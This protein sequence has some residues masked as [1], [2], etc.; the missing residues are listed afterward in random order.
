MQRW[1]HLTWKWTVGVIAA[2]LL[3]FAILVGLFRLLAPLAPGYREQVQAGASQAL[4]RPVN[5]AAVGAQWGLYGPEATLEKV[6]I[7]S[8]DGQRV[9]ISANEIR[10]GYTLGAMLHGRFSRPNRII[11]IQPKLDLD[12]DANGT[13]S[14]HGL[15]SSSAPTNWRQEGGEIFA[16]SADVLVRGGEIT[17]IDKRSS[18]SPLVFS[19]IRLNVENTAD[20]HKVS[21]RL[22]LPVV[23]GRSLSFAGDIQGRA[24][25]PESWQWQAD[26]QGSALNV[27][28]WLSY[29]PIFNKRFSSGQLDL[30]AD[31]SGLGASINRLMAEVH[32]QQ[33]TSTDNHTSQQGFNLLSGTVNWSRSAS[34]WVLTG[35]NMQVQR[36]RESWP[37]SNF[38]LRY[39]HGADESVTW[40]G[41]TSFLRLQDVVTLASW[42]PADIYSGSR[43]MLRLAPSGDIRDIKFQA[44]W[45]GKSIDTWALT[46]SFN[47]L[48]LRADGKIPGFS[49]LSG[50]LRANQDTGDLRFT[51]EHA[52][53]NFPRLFRGPLT[54]TTMSAQVRFLHDAQGWHIFTDDFSAANPDLQVQAKGAFLLPADGSSPLIDLQ[55]SAQNVNVKS[56]STYLPVGI[57]PNKVVNWLDNSIVS[58]QIPSGSLILRGRLQDFP[59]DN[60]QGLFDIRFHLVNGVLDYAA[61]WPRAQDLDADVEF[62]NQGMSVAVQHGTYLGD[63]ISGATANFADLRQGILVIKGTA[64][65][66]AAAALNFLR[67]E[68]LRQYFGH[69]LDSLIAKGR[70][71]VSLHLVLPVEQMDSYT[72]DSVAHLQ[73]V[74]V[75]VVNRPKLQ[76]SRL[77]GDVKITRDGVSSDQLKGTLLGEPLTISL[78]PDTRQDMTL[79]EVE[80]GGNSASLAGV[81]PEPFQKVMSGNTAWQLSGRITSNTGTS[82]KSLSLTLT[83]DLSGLG[84]ELPAPLGKT[85]EAAIPLIASMSYSSDQGML[86]Q[87]RYGD[88]MNGLSLFKDKNGSWRFD[89]GELVFGKGQSSLPSTSG[90]MVTGSLPEFSLGAWQSYAAQSGSPAGQSLPAWL[91]GVDLKVNHFTGYGQAIDN[92]HVLLTR[93]SSIWDITLTSDAVAGKI[94]LPY[95]VDNVHPITADMQRVTWKYKPAKPENNPT[96]STLKPGDVP[97]L[98]IAVKQLR[99]NDL[100][101]ENVKAE[102]ERQ[103]DGINLKSFAITN[104]AFSLT[105]SG[106]WTMQADGKQQSMLK[107]QMKSS[108][109]EKTLQAFGY[110]P[111]ID[112]KQGEM[113]TSLSWPGGPFDNIPPILKG[114]LHMQLKNGRLLEVR[115]G[116]GRLFGL[117]SINALPRRLLLNFS[118]VFGKGF[119]FDSIGGDFLIDHGDAYTKNMLISGPAAK[120]Q[121]VGRIGLVQHDFDEALIVDTSVGASLPVLGA[122]AASSVGVGAVLYILT[123][124]FKKPL[125]AA[126]EI[127]YHLTGTWDNPVLTQVGDDK[128]AAN[129]QP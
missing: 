97:P 38:N 29:W 114:E 68:A 84:V 72:L 21:G 70:S 108:D 45:N 40:S 80:G 36:N 47:D 91:R 56:K 95:T 41:D 28:Q 83:S 103:P 17:L 109:V 106:S 19:N 52:T 57:M 1:H 120:I 67:S 51:G 121:I 12:R 43:R 64:R 77:N 105:S 6:E 3:L 93:D 39:T 32:A 18:T 123:E 2:V 119:A 124:I 104:P 27:P 81:I 96:P 42:L 129:G 54:A 75:A 126:G 49:G 94:T 26:V 50:Q 20:S 73:D 63:D 60:G 16:Q 14:I 61:G 25:Q 128:P 30:S 24:T 8:H 125:A 74:S 101:L 65:G 13:I 76:L 87:F 15:D 53:A 9:V 111:G 99:I 92:L 23:L 62:K 71:D 115:P 46:G 86:L 110:A 118:D 113:Q 122:I 90:L 22:L 82:S 10:L 112:A 102:L 37:A 78:H 5:I 33:L 31:V 7:L 44:Q 55:A 89:R 79:L 69:S 11:L 100:N 116:A 98:Q 48:G 85:A 107:V 34:G 4:G 88:S 117:L 66:S 58:G 35:S 127:R 59:Y